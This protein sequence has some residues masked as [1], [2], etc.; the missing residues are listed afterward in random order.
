MI[1]SYILCGIILE[2]FLVYEQVEGS[3]QYEITIMDLFI[4]ASVILLWPGALFI[5]TFNNTI[6]FDKVL[7][8]LKKKS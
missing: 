2:S 5:R 3:F 6:S 4:A 1:L 8:K 7:F